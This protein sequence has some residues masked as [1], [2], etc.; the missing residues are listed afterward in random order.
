METVLVLIFIS[1]LVGGVG[2]TMMGRREKGR[3]KYRGIRW[4]FRQGRRRWWE[5]P[6]WLEEKEVLRTWGF[7][8]A[9]CGALLILE[10]GMGSEEGKVT[11]LKRPD[12]G[13][14]TI[15]EELELEWTEQNGEKGQEQILVEVKEQKLTRQEKKEI[16][17]EVKEKLGKEILGKNKSLDQV[18]YPL[19][20]PESIKGYP[21]SIC[22]NSSNPSVVDWEGN[23]G[24]EISEEGEEV[25]LIASIQVG[26][27]E[28]EY[29]QQVKVY[30]PNYSMEEQIQKWLTDDSGAW[31]ELPQQIGDRSLSWSRTEEQAI[32]GAAVCVLLVPVLLLMQKKQEAQEKKKR[33]RQQ[34]EQDYPE[35][36]SKLVLLLSA[37]VNLRKSMERIG[38]DYEKYQKQGGER[39]AYEV[40]TEVCKE[41]ERG[42]SEKEAYEQLGERCKVLPYRTLSALLVQHLQK[43]SRGMERILEEEAAR[44]QELRLQQAKIL[45]EQAS[46]KLLVPMVL[47]LVIVFV[48]LLVPAWLSFTVG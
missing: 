21:A 44:A 23:L 1:L 48:I 16:F 30:P 32:R 43:G 34:M 39:K 4:M 5:R 22:W 20:L 33:E 27:E 29:I 7:L 47:M 35:I 45:G 26:E 3:W 31:L 28:E 25:C 40:L 13:E 36:I 18:C 24:D 15:Q 14:G 38:N 37:G 6:E 11:R 17:S 2:L 9:G 46:T 12:Y 41:M 42:V 10:I 19:V 8:V